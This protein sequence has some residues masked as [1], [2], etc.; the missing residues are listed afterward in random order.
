MSIENWKVD[1]SMKIEQMLTGDNSMEEFL[2]KEILR[3]L[4]Y[5]D[6][7]EILAELEYYARLIGKVKQTNDTLRQEYEKVESQIKAI[8]ELLKAINQYLDVL[9]TRKKILNE[10]R[11]L[12]EEIIKEVEDKLMGVRYA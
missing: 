4:D 8:Q 10:I 3:L 9:N 2:L 1:V 12:N 6:S 7:P 11:Q 5:I